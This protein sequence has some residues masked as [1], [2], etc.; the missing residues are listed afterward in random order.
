[1]Q[2]D[3]VIWGVINQSFCSFKVKCV[4]CLA[5]LPGRHSRPRPHAT[6]IKLTW[7]GAAMP[8]VARTERRRK[9]FANTSSMYLASVTGNLARLPTASM[10]RSRRLMECVTCT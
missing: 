1:M 6:V 5:L 7:L 8:H 2:H 10:P 4:V 9:L 3:E